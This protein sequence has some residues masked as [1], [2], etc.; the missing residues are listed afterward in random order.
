MSYLDQNCQTEDEGLQ[1]DARDIAPLLGL[2]PER[3]MAE[4]KAGHI[5]HSAEEATDLLDGQFRLTFRY[6]A[7]SAQLIVEPDGSMHPERNR[8]H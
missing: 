4:L 8:T 3:L 6:R 2:T 5:Y 1:I 7:R